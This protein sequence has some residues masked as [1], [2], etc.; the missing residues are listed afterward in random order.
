MIPAGLRD[1]DGIAAS[2]CLAPPPSVGRRGRGKQRT[3]TKVAVNI[4]LDADV[5]AAFKATGKGWQ[6]R[7]NAALK[8]A[9]KRK[10]RWL[11][12]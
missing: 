8:S 10:S 12:P 5:V 7:I 2:Q 3:P 4:R 11:R 6:G 9:V 1:T